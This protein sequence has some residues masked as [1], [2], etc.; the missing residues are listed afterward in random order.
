MSA[1]VCLL[2]LLIAVT[3]CKVEKNNLASSLSSITVDGLK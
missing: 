1:K 2:T 3:G